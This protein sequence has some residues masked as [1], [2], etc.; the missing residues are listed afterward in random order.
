ML[1]PVTPSLPNTSYIDKFLSA[2]KS[3]LSS[4]K[5]AKND[6]KKMFSS[7]L[8]VYSKDAPEFLQPLYQKLKEFGNTIVQ[9]FQEFDSSVSPLIQATNEIIQQ[10]EELEKAL[11]AYRKEI[12]NVR[13]EETPE[14]I[15]KEGDALQN[16][17]QKLVKF[18][19]DSNALV[20]CFKSFYIAAC[21]QL[22]SNLSRLKF[23]FQ[24]EAE[25]RY[26]SSAEEK[27]IGKLIEELNDE[28]TSKVTENQQNEPAENDKKN[29]SIEKTENIEEEDHKEDEKN[30]E[31]KE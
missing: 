20:P 4:V 2:V 27:E 23:F 29:E 25:K 18:N 31:Q 15:K 28:I 17:I 7:V 1:S 22:E 26:E 24:N 14:N 3:H 8:L 12:I 16:F 30:V 21:A 10:R 5:K 11:S 6:I 9:A 13:A 19:T